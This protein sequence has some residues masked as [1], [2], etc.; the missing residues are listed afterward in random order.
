MKTLLV[1]AL[2][3]AHVHLWCGAIKLA[4]SRLAVSVVCHDQAE[5]CMCIRIY[6]GFTLL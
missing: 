3:Q 6:M 1:R 2:Q 4:T 5:A